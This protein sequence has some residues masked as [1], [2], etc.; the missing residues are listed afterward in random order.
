M[1]KYSNA[2]HMSIT[3]E[4]AYLSA[5][6]IFLAGHAPLFLPWSAFGRVE[7]K[8]CW[9]VQTYTTHISRSGGSVRFQFVSGQLRAALPG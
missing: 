2:A 7:E 4:G 8:T 1:A 9:W 3:P 5:W 6:E